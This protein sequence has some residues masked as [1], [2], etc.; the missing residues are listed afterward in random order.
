MTDPKLLQ[1]AQLRTELDLL[2]CAKAADLNRRKYGSAPGDIHRTMRTIFHNR[3]IYRNT[4]LR[5][6]KDMP[7]AQRPATA[8]TWR[9]TRS[10]S[11]VRMNRGVALESGQGARRGGRS[12][13][14][15]SRAA[16]TTSW[17]GLEA[18]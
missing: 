10:V 3:G 2:R 13:G 12:T 5:P 1:I 9:P 8:L 4:Q 17:G 15:S 11:L 18:R 6:A 7:M 14:R 16:S